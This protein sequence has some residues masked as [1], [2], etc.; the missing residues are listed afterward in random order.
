MALPDKPDLKALLFDA[1]CTLFDLHSLVRGCNEV[2]P[3]RGAEICRLW[4]AKQ[5]EYTHLLSMMGRF[6]D[7]WQVTS[8]ALVTACQSLKLACSP[9]Q[10]DRL[11]ESYFHLE[12]FADVRP[13]LKALSQR[14]PLAILSNGS[15]KM[16]KVV[17]EHNGLQDFFSQIISAS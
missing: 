6:E 3:D 17:V 10:R 2:F 5:L 13:T 15:P 7:F 4:R 11:L 9:E 14:Y 8:K 1:Y 12:V 16:L